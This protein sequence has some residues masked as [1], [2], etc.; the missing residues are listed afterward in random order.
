MNAR[1]EAISLDR[2]R[3]LVQG[4]VGAEALIEASR[5]ADPLL[6]AR[7]GD[8]LLGFVGFVPTSML[9]DSAYA[10]VYTTKAADQHRFATARLARRW[11]SICHSRYPRLVGHCTGHPSSVAW[12]R[13]L[14]AKFGPSELGLIKF[15][16]EVQ[17]G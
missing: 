17:H 7:F 8:E 2:L 16:I 1:M 9:S 3:E 15:T 6:E 14:G 11:K 13:S 4:W 10:W 12:L 5:L